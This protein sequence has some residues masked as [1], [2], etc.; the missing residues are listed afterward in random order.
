MLVSSCADEKSQS[1]QKSEVQKWVSFKTWKIY[2]TN[3]NR[4]FWMLKSKEKLLN[5]IDAVVN[6]IKEASK[7]GEHTYI[8]PQSIRFPPTSPVM[9]DEL[10]VNWPF[11][12]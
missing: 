10:E 6:K 7:D 8:I 9:V 5:P 11:P 4:Q 12:L 3:E 1:G 2:E